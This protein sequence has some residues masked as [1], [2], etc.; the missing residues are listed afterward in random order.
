MNNTAKISVVIPCYRVKNKIEQVIR[1]IPSD[2]DHIIVVDDCCPEKS[3]SYVESFQLERVSVIFHDKNQGVGGAVISGY[4]KALE[5]GCEIAVKIDGDGQ[6]DPS[7]IS[8]F[9]KPII[10]QR[11]HYTKGNRFYWPKTLQAMPFMR[12]I[13]NSGLSF[14]NKV[15]SGQFHLMDPTNGYTALDLSIFDQLEVDKLSKRYF[16]ESDMLFRLYLTRSVVL[17]IPMIPKYEDEQSSLSI[18]KSLFEFSYL[19]LIRTFKRITY[20]YFIRDFNPGSFYLISAVPL[21]SFG[22]FYGAWLWIKAL[23]SGVPTPLGTIMVVSLPLIVG[24]QL[25]ISFFAFDSQNI[26]LYEKK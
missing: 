8:Q 16:F 10:Q 19:H 12:L 21:I 20:T 14:I 18:S 25:L 2:I 26:P 22:L 7:L 9:V 1:S 6:M 11:A 3:G 13:G 17:D 15:S 5:L 24:F 4:K 23:Q